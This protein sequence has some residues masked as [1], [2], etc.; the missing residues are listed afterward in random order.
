MKTKI[1]KCLMFVCL[2]VGVSSAFAQSLI[3]EDLR[4]GYCSHMS[5]NPRCWEGMDNTPNPRQYVCLSRNSCS[6]IK[7]VHQDS[8]GKYHCKDVKGSSFSCNKLVE[9]FGTNLQGFVVKVTVPYF[10]SCHMPGRCVP[11]ACMPGLGVANLDQSCQ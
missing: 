2:T 7:S 8:S 6:V 10:D 9:D 3:I 5:K 11:K 4:P 1:L